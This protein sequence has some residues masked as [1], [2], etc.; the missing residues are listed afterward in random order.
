MLY[1]IFQYTRHSLQS[2]N[3]YIYYTAQAALA[4]FGPT[5]EPMIPWKPAQEQFDRKIFGNNIKRIKSLG[6]ASG[7]Q[8][9]KEEI[10][11]ILNWERKLKSICALLLYIQMVYIFKPWML[12]FAIF[13]IFI[14]NAKKISSG[15]VI[16]MINDT[17]ENEDNIDNDISSDEMDEDDEGMN[18]E[19]VKDKTSIKTKIN[20]IQRIA[21]RVQQFFGKAAHWGERIKNL[22]E[23]KV[24]FLSWIAVVLLLASIVILYLVPLRYLI[25]AGGVNKILK[26]L[27]R[28]DSKG[29]IERLKDF[30]SKVPDDEDLKK[31][32]MV[33]NKVSDMQ[34]ANLDA[35][36]KPKN[37]ELFSRNIFKP[38]YK[39]VPAE[40]SGSL[41]NDYR[42][43]QGG[44]KSSG[45]IDETNQELRGNAGLQNIL[46][47][48]SKHDETDGA[49]RSVQSLSI[50][51]NMILSS[52]SNGQ[53]ECSQ[54]QAEERIKVENISLNFAKVEN[55]RVSEIATKTKEI[56]DEISR[57]TEVIRQKIMA[58]STPKS[59]SKEEVVEDDECLLMTDTSPSQTP[60]L[61]KRDI[62]LAKIKEIKTNPN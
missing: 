34:P 13:I 19:G 22:I 50:D 18:E 7:Y 9:L 51:N 52:E 24:P 28:P 12:P 23:F 57:K 59:K 11:S 36:P 43:L 29:S 33:K 40:I 14:S 21:L 31:L 54:V 1:N 32:N 47:N 6:K 10:N 5:H 26:N 4:S 53:F 16:D 15:V 62:L 41:E 46:H 55:K 37:K 42:A 20:R 56:S 44:I 48:I 2:Y 45:S 35:T 61:R 25:M 30:L 17:N 58:K 8:R 3:Y 38:K 39:S 60:R 49:M 27:I